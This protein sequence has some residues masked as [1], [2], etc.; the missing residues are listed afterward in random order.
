MNGSDFSNRQNI[1]RKRRKHWTIFQDYSLLSYQGSSRFDSYKSSVNVHEIS[2]DLGIGKRSFPTIFNYNLQ[3]HRIATKFLPFLLT[4]EQNMNR[5]TDN[6]EFL[7][8]LNVDPKH[9][10]TGRKSPD[11]LD[12]FCFQN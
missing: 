12:I 9:V 6:Q 4:D 10:V 11:S 1:H 8:L 7:H 3:K 2:E 5:V